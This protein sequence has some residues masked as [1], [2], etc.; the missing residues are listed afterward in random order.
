MVPWT[1]KRLRI[2]APNG[3]QRQNQSQVDEKD[4]IFVF[5]SV[6]YRTLLVKWDEGVR[7]L[8]HRILHDSDMPVTTIK[9]PHF[10]C[11]QIK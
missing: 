3:R 4:C 11:G 9:I 8:D 7:E 1:S 5:L 6:T 10:I 2:A